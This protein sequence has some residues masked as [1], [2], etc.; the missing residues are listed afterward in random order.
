MNKPISH[1]HWSQSSTG[2]GM[3]VTRQGGLRNGEVMHQ[4]VA[5]ME[6]GTES[7]LWVSSVEPGYFKQVFVPW[8]FSCN[9]LL[10]E[11]PLNKE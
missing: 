9:E 6:D 5:T 10:D 11:R 4:V 1:K 2:F 7:G 3:S 8:D